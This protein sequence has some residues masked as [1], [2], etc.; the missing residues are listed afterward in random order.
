MTVQWAWIENNYLGPVAKTIA[1]A[2]LDGRAAANK[3]RGKKLARTLLAIFPA[4]A[5]Q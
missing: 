3:Q 4:A 5:L 1:L 2:S